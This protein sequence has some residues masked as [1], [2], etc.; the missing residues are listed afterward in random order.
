M[1]KDRAA[2]CD[3]ISEMLD[4]PDENGI[5]PTGN[6]Y[7]KLEEYIEGV[8]A[9]AIGWTFAGC[10]RNVEIGADIRRLDVPDILARA[11][12]DLA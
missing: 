11:K 12:E 5:Y 1:K 3:I 2:I 9:E 10:C 7:D 6:A 4:S 8:R